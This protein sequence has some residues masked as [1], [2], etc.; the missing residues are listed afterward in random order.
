MRFYYLTV[1]GS[2]LPNKMEAS[3]IRRKYS[4]SEKDIRILLEN[5]TEKEQGKPWQVR[6][7]FLYFQNLNSSRSKKLF[8]RNST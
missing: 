8:A 6:K 1:D 4:P 2:K 7:M 5:I 3:A